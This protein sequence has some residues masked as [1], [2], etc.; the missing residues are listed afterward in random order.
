MRFLIIFH[1]LLLATLAQK[2]TD[3]NKLQKENAVLKE[4]IAKQKT[5]KLGI[6]PWEEEWVKEI[7]EETLV[8]LDDVMK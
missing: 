1:L 5:N 3:I 6:V 8:K 4:E 2:P 7:S